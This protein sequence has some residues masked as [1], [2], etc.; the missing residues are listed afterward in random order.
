MAAHYITARGHVEAARPGPCAATLRHQKCGVDGVVGISPLCGP[1]LK[2]GLRL[3]PVFLL[4]RPLGRGIRRGNERCRER[5]ETLP[6]VLSR[7]ISQ[8]LN[9]VAIRPRAQTLDRVIGLPKRR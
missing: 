6:A 1:Q 5:I 4:L 7:S 2:E 9:A 3:C 8:T